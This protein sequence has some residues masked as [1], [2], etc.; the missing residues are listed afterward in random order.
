MIMVMI[1]TMCLTNPWSMT[2]NATGTRQNETT[3][4]FFNRVYGNV[5][6][7]TSRY[8]LQNR[9][10][11]LEGTLR[12]IHLVT[13]INNAT[14]TQS[15]FRSVALEN[16]Y[17][18]IVYVSSNIDYLFK[19]Y[20]SV[21][22]T[23]NLDEILVAKYELKDFLL[24]HDTHISFNTSII[25]QIFS[26]IFLDLPP[27]NPDYLEVRIRQ[28]RREIDMAPT[29]DLGNIPLY[30]P[31][32]GRITS[33]FGFRTDPFTG[34]PAWHTGLDIGAPTGTPVYA[35]FNGIATVTNSTGWGLQIMTAQDSVRVR[36]AHLSETYVESGQRVRQGDLIGRVGS[37]GRSTGPHLHLGLYINNVAVNPY[38]IISR[39]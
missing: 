26:P 33:R 18:Q 20:I 19:R 35:W 16:R 23:T 17:Q 32:R 3:S 34:S 8:A 13:G 15:R 38:Y 1:T 11:E 4:E 36:Y 25:D 22:G 39:R 5:F 28:L 2:I 21:L 14:E 37:T 30:L 12:D 27:G 10:H 9:L 6:L 24:L 31:T 29:Y 7:Y